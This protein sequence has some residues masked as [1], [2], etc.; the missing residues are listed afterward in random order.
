MG[1]IAWWLK[2]KGEVAGVSHPEFKILTLLLADYVC[3]LVSLIFS[4]LI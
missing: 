1:N 4:I 2:V 3:G